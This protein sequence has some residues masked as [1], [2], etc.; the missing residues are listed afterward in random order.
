MAGLD[1]YLKDRLRTELSDLMLIPGLSGYVGR[2]RR[3]LAKD[4]QAFG[5]PT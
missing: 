5:L 2:V 1:T 4:L 3:Y